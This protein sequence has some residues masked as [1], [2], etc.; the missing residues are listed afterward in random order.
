MNYLYK[1]AAS[2]IFDPNTHSKKSRGVQSG[3]GTVALV[4]RNKEEPHLVKKLE[5]FA[6]G[7]LTFRYSANSTILHHLHF[8]QKRIIL[9]NYWKFLGFENIGCELDVHIEIWITFRISTN[10]CNNTN[11]NLCFT[12]LPKSLVNN[13]KYVRR[14]NLLFKVRR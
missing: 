11:A 9:Q 10:L 5:H 1:L 12:F 14:R 7:N 8:L 6:T 3:G 4:L 2:R 13:T